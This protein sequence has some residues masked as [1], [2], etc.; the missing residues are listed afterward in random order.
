MNK[1]ILFV[2]LLSATSQ[3]EAQSIKKADVPPVVTATVN[4]LF[5]DASKIKWE[6]EDGMYEASF[7]ADKKETSLFIS[8]NGTLI[9]TEIEIE[10]STLPGVITDFVKQ[11]H[12][13]SSI[14]EASMT[15]DNMGEVIYEVE[16]GDMEYVF[17]ITGR[18]LSQENEEK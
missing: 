13:T 15:T 10:P 18:M 9:M 8:G 2:A 12:A 11:H 17:D 16:V 14:D 7:V 3:L 6:M 5:P 1:F 4:N